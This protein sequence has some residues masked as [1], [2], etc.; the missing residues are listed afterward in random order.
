MLVDILG[1][2]A[3]RKSEAVRRT[4]Q[5]TDSR[6]KHRGSPG[7]SAAKHTGRTDDLGNQQLRQPV[8]ESDD[9][10]ILSEGTFEHIHNLGIM[11]L[12]GHK[13]YDII[14]TSHFLICQDGHRLSEIHGAYHSRTFG[15]Q[16]GDVSL[17]MVDE[18]NLTSVLRNIR[19]QNGSQRT[20]AIDGTSHIP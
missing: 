6:A 14:F 13:E 12:L 8:L 10:T 18:V 11:Q 5:L 16:G 17:V 4:G 20:G 1:N 19:A 2:R 7:D 3:Q 9:H 15:T